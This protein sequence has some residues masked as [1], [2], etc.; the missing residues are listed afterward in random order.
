VVG[1]ILNLAVRFALHVV[2][3]EVGRMDAGPLDPAATVL[4]AS[5][6]VAAFRF[7]VGPATLLAA[8]TAAGLLRSLATGAG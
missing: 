3:R 6:L 1:A 7:G 5:A 2:F 8:A 4:A